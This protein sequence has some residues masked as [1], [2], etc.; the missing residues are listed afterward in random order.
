MRYMYMMMDMEGMR[1]ENE[2]A[3]RVQLVQRT[4]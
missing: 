3:V 4:A 1:D 2:D